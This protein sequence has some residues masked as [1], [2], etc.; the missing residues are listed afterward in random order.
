ME[1]TTITES[2]FV[3]VVIVDGAPR[4]RLVESVAAGRAPY[5]EVVGE[6]GEAQA[7]IQL[8]RD[9][10]PDVVLLDLQLAGA[11]GLEVVRAV[12]RPPHAPSVIVLTNLASIEYQIK[13]VSL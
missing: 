2:A 7:A 11:N 13:W 8:I 1:P 4:A 12:K 5:A 6:A 10:R 9:R 3:R